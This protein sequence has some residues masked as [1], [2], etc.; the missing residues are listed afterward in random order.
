MPYYSDT[1]GGIGEEA[2]GSASSSSFTDPQPVFQQNAFISPNSPQLSL[3]GSNVF[4]YCFTS[5]F[6]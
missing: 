2:T 6:A 1:T 3:D 5:T 4:N